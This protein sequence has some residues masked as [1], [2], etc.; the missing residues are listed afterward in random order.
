MRGRC[1]PFKPQT[2]YQ[3]STL[4]GPQGQSLTPEVAKHTRL[5]SLTKINV[6]C[7]DFISCSL[8]PFSTFINIGKGY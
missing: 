7:Q 2:F 5:H 3:T 4:R 6:R 8:S 1:F